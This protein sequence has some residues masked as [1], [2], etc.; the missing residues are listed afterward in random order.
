MWRK[1][2]SYYAAIIERHGLSKEAGTLVVLPRALCRFG[3]DPRG[4]L[5]DGGL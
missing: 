4:G 2:R 1:D 5:R 3:V